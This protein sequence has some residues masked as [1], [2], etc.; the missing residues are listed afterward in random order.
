M[1]GRGSLL[2]GVKGEGL[3]E[4]SIPNMEKTLTKEDVVLLK[5]DD[6]FRQMGSLKLTG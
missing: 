5:E 1:S 6:I 4:L 2:N 3:C